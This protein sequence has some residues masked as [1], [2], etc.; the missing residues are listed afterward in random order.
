MSATNS[1]ARTVV[2][3]CAIVGAVALAFL[4]GY[5]QVR[6]QVDNQ[7][8][9]LMNVGKNYY[10]Q[11]NGEKAIE[12]F[13]K[14]AA[15][16][17][18]QPD[19]RMNLANASLL[20]GNAE[21]AITH[22]QEALRLE[23]D[24]PGAHYV[25]GCAYLR[26]SRF[27][28]AVKELQIS[29]QMDPLVNAV[30]FQL[31]RAYQG[32]GKLEEAAEQFREVIQFE[33][34]TSP[35]YLA[36][37]YNLGQVLVRLGRHEEGSE[38]LA[39]YQK[40]IADRPNRPTDI[41]ALEHSVYTQARVPFA[42][43][44]PAAKGVPVQF[45]D[46]TG[47]FFGNAAANYRAPIGVID[48]NH[49]GSND[50][51]VAEGTAG[52]RLLMNSNSTF[53]AE[54][55]LLPSTPG[56]RYARCLVGDLN[57]DRF[58]DVV[59]VGDKGVQAFRFATNGVAIEAT[60]FSNL[61]NAPGI[62]GALVD[63]DFTGKLD[64]LLIPPETNSVRVL[65]NLGNMYFKDTT[66]T[67]GVP[68]S[69]TTA[70]QLA[71]EDWNNDD[72]MDV[73]V[74]RDGQPPLVLV[75]ERGGPLTDT[76]SPMGWPAGSAIAAGDL[77]ND[78][79]NDA[80][81]AAPGG[82]ECV[83]AGITNRLRLPTGG[84]AVSGLNLV[85]YDN[86]G[87]LDI[88]ARGNGVRVWRNLGLAGFRETTAELRLDKVA[89]GQVDQVAL[90]DF[91]NDGDTDFLLGVQNGG[92]KLLR[93]EGGNAN[94]QIK[95]R[96]LGNRS[97]FTGLGVRIEVTAGNWRTIR[98][99][100]ELPVEIGVGQH[101]QLDSLNIHWVDVAAPSAEV[102]VDPRSTLV[103]M[104][105]LLP[106][107]SC[108]YLYAWDG[109][110]FRFITDILGAAPAG[111]P[112]AEGRMVEADP[113]EYVWIGNED[114]FQARAGKLVLQITEELREVLYLDEAKLVVADHPAGTEAHP[115]DKMLPSRP[116]P[117]SEL[118]T[119][120]HRYPLLGAERLDGTDVTE[121]VVENDGKVLS[122]L[123]L[124]APQLRGLA[125][126]HGVVADFGQLQSD[127][128]LAL[129]LSGWLRFGG[130]MANIAASQNPNLPFP[131]PVLEVEKADGTW[132]PVDVSVGV[133]AGKTK[134][135]VV[136]LTGKLPHGSRRL[137]LSTAFELHWDRVALFERHQAGETKIA[138]LAPSQTDLHWRGFSEFEDL[139]W[140]V[141][142]T[143]NYEKVKAQP[144][145]LLTPQGWCTR[146]GQVD[147]L[148]AERDGALVLLN[149]G[150]ELTLSFPADQLPPKPD[151][152]T[153]DF[154]LFSVGWD[155]DADFH[156]LAGTTVEPIPFEGMDDQ[157]YSE[158]Q[159]P[160]RDQ[161]WWIEKYNTRW[162]GSRTFD[163]K[164][165]DRR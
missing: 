157:R 17:P 151:G 97:N 86:D 67:S 28:D 48:I 39:Q 37:Q 145:W 105:L 125:E 49:R 55:E 6:P 94:Q 57:N 10:E 63:L 52:F 83:F 101:K 29:K 142:L 70:R 102:P 130:G 16:Q 19:V 95:L 146:Y 121:L 76:N 113:D 66:S 152:Y 150:D 34:P 143:P 133:P 127:R 58:E 100:K 118:V 136:D 20:A 89:T 35:A 117:K 44:Q 116:F 47:D 108:P 134:T 81:I 163:R 56:A 114:S 99:V 79:R 124:R 14:A 53:Q 161:R 154:F 78:F 106:T 77:N 165:A 148:L 155:K 45:A 46:A 159:R 54:G 13:S 12:A 88:C 120:G 162:V 111:L 149:G 110:R 139:P 153:R 92:L 42:I 41:A 50:I 11:G 107:G 27:E 65:R 82:L 72:I 5:W 33:E 128:P 115:T 74:V 96:L 80:V 138:V 1:T 36:A 38:Q 147:E 141:P 9:R 3:F 60:A 22:A 103:I 30:S 119:V 26:L 8:A 91:D 98:T 164:T 18:V 90:A 126:P 21:D 7:F 71:I 85:D 24:S 2:Y 64:L 69:L 68:A 61:R 131:F 43:D 4:F 140:F 156:V 112:I 160:S 87:W 129:V 93:N 144:N 123:K 109:E 75:K 84:F 40:L 15:L 132:S 51:F 122:P 135:I 31:G 62:D 23:P 158:P 73:W 59:M 137:K 25:M 104:E 32:W